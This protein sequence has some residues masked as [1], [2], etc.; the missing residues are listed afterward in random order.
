MPASNSAVV[1]GYRHPLRPG[2][3]AIF[4]LSG[5]YF[6]SA[7]TPKAQTTQEKE[8]PVPAPQTTTAT[9]PTRSA[10]AEAQKPSSL[11]QAIKKKKVLTEDDLHP[12]SGRASDTQSDQRDF[13]PICVSACE[14]RVRDAM[15]P[16]DSSELDFRNKLALASQQIDDD[17]KWG[18]ALVEAMHAADDYC[19]LERNRGKYAYRGATPPYTTD[20]LSFDFIGKER[21]VVNKYVTAKGNVDL[22]IRAMQ[23]TDPFRAIVMQGI[24]DAALERSCGGVDHI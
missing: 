5:S 6:C 13:N 9:K 12:K 21:D 10:P 18:N 1:R 2:L 11:K 20:K 19:D 3:F 22:P 15:Q 16:D 4:I 23:Y 24:W 14:Q 17:R 7:Q 8:D